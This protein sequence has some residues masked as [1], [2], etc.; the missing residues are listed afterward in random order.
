MR[1]TLPPYSYVPGLFPHPESDPTGHGF[2][3]PSCDQ[4][5]PADW[6]SCNAYTRGLD[7]FNSGYYWEAHECWEAVW[8]CC[9][10]RGLT[11]DFLKALIK[12]AAAL[13]KAREGRTEGVRRH[14]IRSAELVERTRQ[15]CGTHRYMG[16]EL[17]ELQALAQRLSSAPESWINTSPDPVVCFHEFQMLVSNE[18]S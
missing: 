10:R 17:D 7:L 9:G 18:D 12:L 2:K 3:V 1:D 13:V 16:L 8:N 11:A 4:A 15:E 14:A 6:K 5:D